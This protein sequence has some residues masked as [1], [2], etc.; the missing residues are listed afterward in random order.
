MNDPLY[1]LISRIPGPIPTI[2]GEIESNRY[3]VIACSV[4]DENR[5]IAISHGWSPHDA[6]GVTIPSKVLSGKRSRTFCRVADR[7][8]RYE[9]EDASVNFDRQCNFLNCAWFPEFVRRM[10]EGEI[11]RLRELQ[12]AY[13]T[14]PYSYGDE[15]PI[16]T[17]RQLEIAWKKMKSKYVVG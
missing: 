12:E 17:W 15:M 10:A 5:Q 1:C 16:G 14:Y 7:K 13:R 9:L 11:I 3:V 2:N 4:A 6:G 8:L